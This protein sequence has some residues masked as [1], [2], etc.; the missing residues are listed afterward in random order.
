MARQYGNASAQKPVETNHTSPSIPWIKIAIGIGAIIIC[1]SLLLFGFKLISGTGISTKEIAT[2]CKKAGYSQITVD[3]MIDILES[4]S[5]DEY[6]NGSVYMLANSEEDTA[7]FIE[8]GLQNTNLLGDISS[9]VM[10]AQGDDNSSFVILGFELKSKE[11]SNSCVS[12]YVSSYTP[13]GINY[14][15]DY[16]SITVKAITNGIK[17]NISYYIFNYETK[18]LDHSYT[19]NIAAIFQ[20]NKNV[21]ILT[22]ID[23]NGSSKGQRTIN[24]TCQKLGIITPSEA[25]SIGSDPNYYLSEDLP[26][27]NPIRQSMEQY[28][29]Q[30]EH[31]LEYYKQTLMSN[32]N[33]LTPPANPNLDDYVF[34]RAINGYEIPGKPNS[35]ISAE[36]YEKLSSNYE[37]AL[38]VFSSELSKRIVGTWIA[39]LQTEN[40]PA[41]SVIEFKELSSGRGTFLVYLNECDESQ[42]LSFN[43]ANYSPFMD[44]DTKEL[45]LSSNNAFS[46]IWTISDDAIV[47]V[48]IFNIN[49][50]LTDLW[51][52][53][54][55]TLSISGLANIMYQKSETE[56]I[57]Y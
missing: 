15:N 32:P 4:G 13:S 6:K 47:H 55:G 21:Y 24:D 56:T 30:Y 2:Y 43:I 29:I 23:G 9:I 7:N 53:E 36:D 33:R 27:D 42:S 19:E 51:V 40:G 25:L 10:A 39:D 52:N 8:Y 41:R 1:S 14:T 34:S 26:E 28:K 49:T 54:D 44:A 31:S 3:E 12:N 38:E 37:E 20:V 50:G 17:D 57:Y 22:A 45:S 18:L 48:S 11:F 5:D 35:R 16:S 46:G